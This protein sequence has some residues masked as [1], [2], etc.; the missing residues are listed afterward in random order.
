MIICIDIGNT[1]IKYAI[2]DGDALRFSYR[3]ATD[4]KRT[5]DEYGAQL[6]SMLEFNGI[7][8]A[9]IKGGIF[10]SVV[11]SLDYTIDHML[12]LYLGITPK[13][14]APGLKTGL[15]MRA[16]NAREVGADRIVNN[17]SAI[18]KYGAEKPM[19]VVDFGTATTF[20]II[21]EKYEFIGGV[22]APGI[23]GS[24]DSLVSG[25]AKLPRVEIEAPKSVIATNTVTN[26]Q[27]GIVFGFAGLVEYIV[28]KI[29]T[30][31]GVKDVLTVAT[32]GF[33]GIIAK[34]TKCIDV[35]D[36]M[37][38]LNGLKYL[39]DLNDAEETE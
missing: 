18:R 38:T 30:E 34:E 23:R 10:S 17:V 7:S 14:I 3:V 27:A 8:V 37:L 20:N 21:N 19:I 36:K 4:L 24:L 12:R 26:M 31:L 6:A 5:S 22:I 25:T 16:D 33:S 9:E 11:P 35:I 13:Q 32:G 29:K 15:A 1:N 28:K 39:Y 2:F